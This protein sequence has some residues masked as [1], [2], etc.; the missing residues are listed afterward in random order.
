[1]FLDASSLVAIL[2]EE[3]AGIALIQKIDM[4]NGP[5]Y[6]SSLVV[7]EATVSLARKVKTAA[8]GAEAPTPPHMVERAQQAVMGFLAD[9]G[10]VEVELPAGLHETALLAARTYGRFVGHPA[11]LNFGDCFSYAMA[12]SL[13][14]PLLFV[15]EDFVRTDIEVA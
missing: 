7:F 2:G 14:V 12:R 11:K 6:Y 4:A 3:E 13:K 5:I 8:L 15:G 1:M 10:A 9:L